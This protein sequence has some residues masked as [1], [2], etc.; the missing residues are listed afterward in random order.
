M[1][2]RAPRT[3][4]CARALWLLGLQPPVDPD[5]LAAAW[6]RRVD[7]GTPRPARR[8]RA[9]QRGRD[10]ADARAERRP[11]HGAEPGSRAAA[12]GRS[13]PWEDAPCRLSPSH[14]L[15]RNRPRPRS[16]STPACGPATACAPGPTTA[17]RWPYAAPRW[18]R[19]QAPSGCCWPTARPPLRTACGWRHTAAPSAAP[20]R[21]RSTAPSS[22]APAATAS[23][24]CAGW[25]SG[26]PRA[27]RIR[28]AIE[29]RSEAGR[30]TARSL[31]SAWLGERAAERGR[32]A[33]RLRLASPEDLHAALL[34]AFTRA[35][36]RWA[37]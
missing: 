24:T 22:R 2:R 7:A 31:D 17:T 12:S 18:R 8:V 29:A 5:E 27:P 26:R 4:D 23:A 11:G 16:A 10:R 3:S 25:S 28:T 33:R 20:A 6:K 37:A 34:G 36:E 35:F 14:S 30:A 21:A 9:A 1:R 19:A 32:W 15:I 13:P